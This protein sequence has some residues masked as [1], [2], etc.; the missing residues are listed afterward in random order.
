MREVDG[1]NINLCGRLAEVVERGLGERARRDDVVCAEEAG[2]GGGKRGRGG[3]SG[4]EGEG[5]ARVL[6]EG[7]GGRGS[8]AGPVEGGRGGEREGRQGGE[9]SGVAAVGVGE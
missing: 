5:D 3:G 2:G 6:A 7:L 1:D 9:G 4:V 8:I